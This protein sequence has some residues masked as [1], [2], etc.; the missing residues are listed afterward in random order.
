MKGFQGEEVKAL[1]KSGRRM[2]NHIAVR[3]RC[4]RL[5]VLA[6]QLQSLGATLIEQVDQ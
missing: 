3:V 5:F 6:R 2:A 4:P 1:E